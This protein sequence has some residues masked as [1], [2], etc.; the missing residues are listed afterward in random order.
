MVLELIILVSDGQDP[1]T[2]VLVGHSLG[3]HI[4]GVAG[5]QVK[6]LT[7]RQIGRIMAL[8]PAGPCF[9]GSADGRIDRGDADYVEV[10]HTN[11]GALGL[12]EPVG[13]RV[14]LVLRRLRF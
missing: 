12:K 14:S 6:R 11:G 10:I 2:I 8:D 5:K 3:S 13:K 7:G 4:A 1:A 9:G